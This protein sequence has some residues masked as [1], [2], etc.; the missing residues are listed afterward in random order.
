MVGYYKNLRHQ[1]DFMIKKNMKVNFFSQKNKLFL[2]LEIC[3]KEI[4]HKKN[5]RCSLYNQITLEI[6]LHGLFT[7]G[8]KPWLNRKT[9]LY[10]L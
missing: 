5:V 2:Y 4:Y 9:D 3:L 6:F 1:V 8:F 7:C 10:I